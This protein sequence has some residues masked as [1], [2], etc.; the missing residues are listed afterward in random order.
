MFLA[1]LVPM[2]GSFLVFS[3]DCDVQHVVGLIRL[4]QP[5]LVLDYSSAIR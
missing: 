3:T 4:V 5:R 2:V 1:V